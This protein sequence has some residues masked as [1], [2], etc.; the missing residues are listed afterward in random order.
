M[1]RN[2]VV[3]YDGSDG[4]EAA[5]R[6]AAALADASGGTIH[7]VHC[8][9]H[10]EYAEQGVVQEDSDAESSA[11]SA[12]DKAADQLD[13]VSVVTSVVTGSPVQGII[14]AAERVH[15]D[16]IVA[17]SRGKAMMPEAVLG[18]VTSGVVNSSPCD[19]LVVHPK[20]Q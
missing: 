7:L 11:R 14:G 15:A 9:G 19:V 16:V 17:G 20:G 10:L 4:A 18:R 2:I 5:L 6:S 12:L 8:T 3:A 1:Y 13:E